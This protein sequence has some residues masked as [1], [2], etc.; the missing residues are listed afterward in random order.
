MKIGRRHSKNSEALA[1]QRDG[2]ADYT[3]VRCKS[4]LPETVTEN[5]DRTLKRALAFFVEKSPA[6]SASASKKR[7]VI[8]G[9]H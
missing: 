7:K 8:I 5:S 9:N 4:S 1:I 3:L 2:S 6:E